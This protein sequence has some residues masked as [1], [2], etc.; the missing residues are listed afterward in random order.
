MNGIGLVG[1]EC[2]TIVSCQKDIS[3]FSCQRYSRP[4]IPSVLIEKS[5]CTTWKVILEF[6]NLMFTVP[7]V[8]ILHC[9]IPVIYMASFSSKSRS[10]SK[11]SDLIIFMSAPVSTRKLAF[12]CKSS[13]D[14]NT[15]TRDFR[16]SLV[17]RIF[18][19]SWEISRW[20]G[21]LFSPCPSLRLFGDQS[22]SLNHFYWLELVTMQIPRVSFV[23]GKSL[24]EMLN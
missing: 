21:A 13:F 1:L 2:V 20:S 4:N 7:M 3:T 5:E 19:V 10:S 11:A 22:W 8:E 18:L 14:E 6:I 23:R 16:L 15:T 12:E 24:F 17:Q 9:V